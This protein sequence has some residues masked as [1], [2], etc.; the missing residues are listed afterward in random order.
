MFMERIGAFPQ[1]VR[2]GARHGAA[3]RCAS[4]IRPS[5][6]PTRYEIRVDGVAVAAGE[7]RTAAVAGHPPG[8]RCPVHP[9]RGHARPDLWP[10]RAVDRRRRSATPPRAAKFTLVDAAT[11]LHDA[12]DRGAAPR[13]RRAA[14]AR[15]N[16]RAAGARAAKPAGPGRG[17]GAHGAARSATCRRCCRT[18]CARRCRSATWRRSSRRWPTRAAAARTPRQLTELVRQRPGPRDLPGRCWAK[19]ARC[20]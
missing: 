20:T 18:C 11:V 1:A 16:R 12:P 19:P 8:R 3:Q 17:A 13:V 6:R 4:A 14:D 5:W 15:R 7:A 2:A 10:A 9:R